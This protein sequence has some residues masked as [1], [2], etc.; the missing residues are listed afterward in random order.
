VW[1][2][3]AGRIPV[4]GTLT[5]TLPDTLAQTPGHTLPAGSRRFLSPARMLRCWQIR[6]HGTHR[7]PGRCGAG[8]PVR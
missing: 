6:V 5:Q 3:C 2:L 4:S 7:L 8:Q 1:P